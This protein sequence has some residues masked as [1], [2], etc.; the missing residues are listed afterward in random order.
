MTGLYQNYQTQ[1]T[2]P[3]DLSNTPTTTRDK[4]ADNTDSSTGTA[5]PTRERAAAAAPSGKTSTPG[6]FL[7]CDSM[8]ILNSAIHH[9][10]SI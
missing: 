9:L 7:F 3:E 6:N 1:I 2:F 5:A 8:D 10:S 4:T